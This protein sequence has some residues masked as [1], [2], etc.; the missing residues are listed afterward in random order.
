MESNGY[1][2]TDVGYDDYESDFDSGFDADDGG[3]PDTVESELDAI[4]DLLGG[5]SEKA[6]ALAAQREKT[7]ARSKVSRQSINL[8]S[9]G[10]KVFHESSAAP[11]PKAEER[12]T[13]YSSQVREAQDTATQM[14]EQAHRENQRLTELYESGQL[15]HSD[16]MSQTHALGVQAGQAKAMA[17]QARIAE[18]EHGQQKEAQHKAL[19]ARLG[20]AWSPENRQQTMKDMVDW[21]TRAGV[22]IET[23]AAVETED[24][25]M[26]IYK[27]M[28]NEKELE[29]TKLELK[30]ARAMLKK[31]SQQLKGRRRKMS[32]DAST[33]MRN[34]DAIDQ[35]SQLLAE[36]GITGGRR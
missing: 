12:E 22:S 19:E 15:S 9:H 27:A 16:Y 8:D 25:A 28:K 17:M 4:A 6:D 29:A 1:E 21:A 31:Q 33:G 30:A 36:H 23:L 13:I 10:H 20:E 35:V 34:A 14:W 24:E 2:G 26:A 3:V 7:G 18:L 32:K 11:E 5:N